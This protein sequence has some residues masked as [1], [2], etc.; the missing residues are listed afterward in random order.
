M[1][2]QR[3]DIE[4]EKILIEAKQFAEKSCLLNT[5]FKENRKRKKKKIYNENTIDEESL[6]ENLKIYLKHISKFWIKSSVL[7]IQD[8]MMLKIL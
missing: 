4:Y 5:E 2:H 1:I 7:L 3:N 6:L 8:L